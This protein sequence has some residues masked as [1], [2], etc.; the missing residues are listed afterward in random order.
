MLVP[1]LTLVGKPACHLCDEARA[2]VERVVGDLR[3]EGV[4]VAVA[5]RSILDDAALD[6]RWHDDIPVV[7]IGTALHD[8]W[9]ID[10]GR[11]RED[12]LAAAGA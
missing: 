1:E 12:L 8:R 9:R 3:A 6:A 11:L 2:V 10:A 5:E 4:E 7:L